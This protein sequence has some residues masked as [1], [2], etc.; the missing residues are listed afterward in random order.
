[1]GL[2]LPRKL[3]RDW[4]KMCGVEGERRSSNQGGS[5]QGW[6]QCPGMDTVLS[7]HRAVLG[8]LGLWD[9]QPGLAQDLGDKE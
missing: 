7:V 6:T 1:M 4:G 8:L 9:K 5:A 2:A 3:G